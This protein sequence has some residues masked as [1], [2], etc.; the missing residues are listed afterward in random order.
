MKCAIISLT[1]KHGCAKNRF[2]NIFK[3][4]GRKIY[5]I[6]IVHA[7]MPVTVYTLGYSA[8][9]VCEFSERKLHSVVKKCISALQKRGV[10]SVYLTDE[11][12][13]Y[14][15]RKEFCNAFKVAE[16]HQIFDSLLRDVVRLCSREANLDLPESEVGIWQHCFD[17]HGYNILENVC[18][19][20][21]YITLFTKSD[22]AAR[23]YADMLY[24]KAGV[25]VK[26]SHKLSQLNKCD[27]VILTDSLDKQITNEN[28]VVID[29]CGLYPYRCCN[30]IEFSLPFGF[31]AL[32]G[33]F[34]TANQRCMEFL[35]DVCGISIS[36]NDNTNELLENIGCSV[37]K[38]LYKTHKNI[39][40]I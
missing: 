14:I 33:Y 22:A 11:V 21:K 12:I 18:D 31:N 3:I 28:T 2:S 4:K 9:E 40:K 23:V 26:V 27:V 35:F 32:M 16:G 19:D 17:E 38:I 30:T 37:K 29:E 10:N 8:G 7:C 15:G 13:D 1:E 24:E 36:K 25:S 39:D 34:E 5:E 6:D 20:F